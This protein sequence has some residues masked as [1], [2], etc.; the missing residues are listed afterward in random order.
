MELYAKKVENF[1]I[2]NE[3]TLLAYGVMLKSVRNLA[4]IEVVVFDKSHTGRYLRKYINQI[5]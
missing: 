5:S 3:D 4:N 1:L 2:L